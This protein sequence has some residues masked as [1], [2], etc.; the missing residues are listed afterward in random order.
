MVGSENR[1]KAKSNGSIDKAGRTKNVGRL[2]SGLFKDLGF[3]KFAGVFRVFMSLTSS[4]FRQTGFAW[5][6][7]ELFLG[8]Y[9]S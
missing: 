2:E 1:I 8:I 5:S 4:H 3:R 6:F 7:K 9:R